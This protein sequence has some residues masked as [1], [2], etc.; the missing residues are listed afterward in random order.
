MADDV[1]RI[2]T[3]CRVKRITTL[4]EPAGRVEGNPVRLAE[5]TGIA[6]IGC[7]VLGMG[8]VLDL[9]KRKSGLPR[10]RATP[11]CYSRTS[12]ART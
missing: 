1:P 9:T 8:F 12:T 11:R 4:L 2:A 5:N 6:F 10:I 7:Y 3:T